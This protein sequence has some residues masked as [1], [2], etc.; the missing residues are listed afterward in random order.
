[1]WGVGWIMNYDKV[2]YRKEIES[3]VTMYEDTNLPF[4][5]NTLKEQ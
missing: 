1:M 3:L 5:G 4:N 2:E